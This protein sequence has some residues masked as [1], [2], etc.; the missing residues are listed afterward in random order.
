MMVIAMQLSAKKEAVMEF[1]NLINNVSDLC[2]N[3]GKI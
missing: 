2:R 3:N 1:V